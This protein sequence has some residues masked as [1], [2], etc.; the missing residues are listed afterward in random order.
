MT[1]AYFDCFAGA[2]GDMI[3]A[4][5]LDAGAD[6]DVLRQHVGR[7]GIDGLELAVETVHRKAMR[8]LHF[9]VRQ[10][11]KPAE[12]NQ[13][14][15]ADGEL[16][17]GRGH[18]HHH[19]HH[20]RGLSDILAMI[21]AAALPGRAAER[22]KAVFHRLADAEA[23]VHGIDVEEVHFHEVGAV[24]SIVDVVAA[25][26]AME[27]LGI[28]RV[29]CSPIPTGS[30]T[31]KCAHGE[32]P[33]PAPA[34]AE[35]LVGSPTTPGPNAGEATTPTAA[36]L[37]TTLAESFGPLPAMKTS[38]VGWGAGTREGDRMPNLLRV[39]VGEASPAG[40]ADTAVELSANLD[41]CTGE[42]I[43]ATIDRLLLAGCFDAWATPAVMKKSRPAWV[44][45][46]LCSPADEAEATKIILTETTTFGLRR[47]LC[48]RTKLD[49]RIETVETRYGPV[50]VKVGLLDGR[51]VTASPEFEDCRRTAETNHLPVREVLAEA[52]AAYR[53]RQSGDQ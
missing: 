11:G 42:V 29:L 45:S 40:D 48:G 46:A 50:R 34:T 28:D 13:A 7:L 15:E 32:L 38:A 21:D 43:G 36:A 25:C 6:L 37:L 5:L 22:A 2:G 53:L 33:V 1:I 3:V 27:L 20:H 44:L 49:R 17:E 8:G 16:R 35:L 4:A 14:G 51:E 19:E 9:T 23:K 10:H 30:G 12:D 39:F 24:D 41:D 52:A 18:H 47:R 31:V 26:V